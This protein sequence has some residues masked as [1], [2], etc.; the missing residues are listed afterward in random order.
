MDGFSFEKLEV[1]QEAQILVSQVYQL[2]NLLPKHETYSLGTQLR[3]SIISVSSNIAEGAG[4]KS[5]KEKLHFIEISTGSLYESY[6]QLQTCV[7]LGYIQPEQF[8]YLKPYFYR[9][10]RLL[11]GLHKSFSNKLTSNP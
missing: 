9:T 1:Y 6:C 3:R 4:R 7:N 2:I 8:Y 5:L 11:S 10:S